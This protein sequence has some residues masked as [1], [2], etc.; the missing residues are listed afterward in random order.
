MN[1]EQ[2]VSES[3]AAIEAVADADALEAIRI[4]ALGKQGWVSQALKSLGAMPPEERT[5]AAP[6]IQAMR[7][8]VADAIAA[9]KAALDA[10]EV[11]G[12]A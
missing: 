6:A 11:R 9:K 7:S 10:A 8:R 1:D 12:E 2:R 3:L 5:K 4:A